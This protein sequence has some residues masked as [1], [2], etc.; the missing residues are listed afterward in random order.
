MNEMELL[1][2]IREE[3]R[4]DAIP[5]RP[6][7]ALLAAI[8]A[9]GTLAAGPRGQAR[10]GALR[11]RRPGRAWR[12]ALAGGLS[13]ALAAG[14]AVQV[15]PSGRSGS[16]A[17]ITVR[18]LAYR[19][20]AAAAAQPSVAPGQW[21]Y[22]LEKQAGGDPSGVFQV[23]TT[24]DSTR[25]AYVYRGK[26]H[27]LQLAKPGSQSIGQP[28]VF[29]SRFGGTLSGAEEGRLPIS[30]A[31]LGSLPAS[32]RALD[33]Y[34]GGLHLPG[35][36]SAPVREFAVIKDLLIT[37]VMPPA[38]TAELY[39]AVGDIPGVTVV[40]HAVDAA[41]RS[42]IGFEIKSRGIPEEIVFN[43]RT[44]RLM[45]QQLILSRSGR[46]VLNGTAIL[47]EAPVSGPGV[48]P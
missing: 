7:T 6:Q 33:R 46:S 45:G 40:Q 15:V 10:G 39:Q 29:A 31:G 23:W 35:W 8:K 16:R 20:S 42:G 13:L 25:A 18:E 11:H 44:Y 5:A 37:Y 24:A 12:F 34:I 22:W 3:F 19:T 36:G 28:A 38:L 48:K 9:E 30:Y 1:S 27:F 47:R 43:P 21:M 14:V 2:H 26:V 41:G 4:T 17:G 32:P